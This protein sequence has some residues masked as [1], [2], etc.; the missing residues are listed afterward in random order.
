MKAILFAVALSSAASVMVSN[1]PDSTA[2]S[3]NATANVTLADVANLHH[4]LE[5]IALA[6]EGM[7]NPSHKGSLSAAKV[8]PALRTFL[9]ELHTT[10][11]ATASSKD[12]PAA[13]KRLRSAQAGIAGLTQ[14][15]NA[16]QENLMK[17]DATEETNLLLGVLMTRKGEP[18]A[19]QL[20]VLA[21]PDFMGLPVSKALLLKHD[22]PTPLFQQVAMYMDKHGV[23][24][25]AANADEKARR[26][27]KTLSYFA[28]K[29]ENLEHEEQIMQQ[30]Q[31][32][33]IEEIDQ[34]IKTAEKSDKASSHRLQLE[35]KHLARD[36]K[37]RVAMHKEQ[38]KVMK[39]VVSAL[40]RGDSA[41]LKKAQAALQA[42]LQA[43]KAQTGGF[44]YLLQLGHRLSERDCPFCVAQCIGKCHDA[45]SPY[46]LCMPECATSGQ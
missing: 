42:H 33:S 29:V 27:S 32:V 21:S 26:M 46:S 1:K 20:E 18:M 23:T 17:E 30:K 44:L 40:K 28:E 25:N 14:A 43:M 39:D 31:K 3:M 12:A 6:L 15:L 2:A 24:A 10:L 41:A 22:D 13:M 37:K 7:L 4:K 36:Y 34:L 8:A 38:T 9:S 45:G 5:T 19:K 16:Q 11:N 35:K